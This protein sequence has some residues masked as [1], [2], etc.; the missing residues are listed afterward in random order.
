M[1]FRA[2]RCITEPESHMRS[3]N[4]V[5]GDIQN[6][7]GSVH[8]GR[9]QSRKQP[10]G[11]VYGCWGICLGSRSLVGGATEDEVSQVPRASRDLNKNE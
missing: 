9:E 5:L 6:Y 3:L 1:P 8:R 2:R 4:G 7:L 11:L 10:N